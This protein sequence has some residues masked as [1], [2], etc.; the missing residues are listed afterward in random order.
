MILVVRFDRGVVRDIINTPVVKFPT[1]SCMGS[2]CG[3]TPSLGV[4]GCSGRRISVSDRQGRI[5]PVRDH[6]KLA[7]LLLQSCTEHRDSVWRELG[8]LLHNNGG[9]GDMDVSAIGVSGPTENGGCN[10]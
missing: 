6:G 8:W 4:Q 2:G 10:S 5:G 7:N 9:S 1:A 3:A